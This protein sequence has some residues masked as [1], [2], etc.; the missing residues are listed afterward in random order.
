MQNRRRPARQAKTG[1]IVLV[2][3]GAVAGLAIGMLLADRMGGLEALKR[4][5][6]R[7]RHRQNGWRTDQHRSESFDELPD[8]HSELAPEAISHLHLAEHFVDQAPRLAE[9]R[10]SGNRQTTSRRGQSTR[11]AADPSTG[12]ASSAQPAASLDELE[13]RVLDAFQNDP[14]LAHRSIDI[15]AVSP[16][17]VELTGWVAAATEIDYALTIA[18]GV[19]GVEYVLNS[20][21]ANADA[22]D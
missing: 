16:G 5:P 12:R 21:S 18:R 2:A 14:I 6:S 19:P 15:G 9:T 8:D 17:E 1:R 4:S 20:L 11:P 22:V 13:E 7:R 10:R 3:L